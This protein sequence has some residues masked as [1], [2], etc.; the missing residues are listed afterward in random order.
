MAQR[1]KYSNVAVVVPAFNEASRISSTIAELKNYFSEIIVVDDGSSDATFDV[2]VSAGVYPV[3]HP[4]NLGQGAALQ[5]GIKVALLD[6]TIEAILTFDADG[7]H[8][9]ESAL[10]LI[11]E[12]RTSGCGIILGSRYCPGAERINM[13]L[14]KKIILRLAILFT[15]FDSGLKVTDTHNG[16]RVMSREFANSLRIKQHGMAHASEILNHVSNSGVKWKEVPVRIYYT[17]YSNKKGQSVWNSV[18]IITE[19]LNR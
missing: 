2:A 13:P 11:E 3:R 8:S 16:L 10:N 1:D 14:K 17:E 5:T 19:L 12:I 7:Q 4:M 6:P 18:N 9:I 15:R